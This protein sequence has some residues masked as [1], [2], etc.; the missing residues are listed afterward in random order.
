MTGRLAVQLVVRLFFFFFLSVLVLGESW[1]CSVLRRLFWSLLSAWLLCAS[2]IACS[3]VCQS[4]VFLHR[5]LLFFAYLLE[6]LACHTL[7]FT[8]RRGRI[9][10][11]EKLSTSDT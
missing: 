5:S 2:V 10:K 1:Q 3:S 9:Q 11:K 8:S 7:S 4:F 6:A